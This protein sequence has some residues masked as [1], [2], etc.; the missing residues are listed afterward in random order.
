ME[1]T[2]HILTATVMHKRLQPKLNQFKYKTY[3]L[4]LPLAKLHTAMTL[5]Y[6]PVNKFGL[7]SFYERDHGD[8]TGNIRQWID[9]LLVKH[10]LDTFITDIVLVCM[11]RVLGYVFNPVSFW[12]CLDTQGQ[13]RAVLCEVNNTFGETHCYLCVHDTVDVI[14]TNDWLTAQKLFHVSPF[15]ER[16]GYYR[17]RFL[18]KNNTFGVWIHLHDPDGKPQLITSLYGRLQPLTKTS[19]LKAVCRHP[20]VT[21][22]T[23]LLIHWQALKL[24]AKG[25]KYVT[26]PKPL[27][28][29]ISKT[30]RCK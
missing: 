2:P 20:L 14:Q 5:K 4:A 23:I 24:L 30:R 1:M 17:F 8:R 19:L 15:F 26:K 10:R 29:K 3:Y 18:F 7:V 9:E 21:F 13:L 16:E 28:T 22:K 6:L 11:P 27:T 25:I 12:L